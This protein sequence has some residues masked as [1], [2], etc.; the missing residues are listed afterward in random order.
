MSR[1]EG[2]TI[3]LSGMPIAHRALLML[4]WEAAALHL[5]LQGHTGEW[6]LCCVVAAYLGLVMVYEGLVRR[7]RREI[8]R[9][10]EMF[11]MSARR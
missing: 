6:G 1:N 5:G 4:I 3:Q 7:Q 10:E 9:L 11:K 2:T 8:A